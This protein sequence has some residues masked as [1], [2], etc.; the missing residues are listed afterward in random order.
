MGG[1]VALQPDGK[2]LVFSEPYTGIS[3]LRR[4]NPDGSAD[5]TF[6]CT[7]SSGGRLHNV[8]VLED[9]KILIAGLFTFVNGQSVK[10]LARLNANGS[11]DTSFAAQLDDGSSTPV[12]GFLAVEPDGSIIIEGEFTSAGGETNMDLARLDADGDAMPFVTRGDQGLQDID[13]ITRIFDGRFVA[14][15]YFL[16]ENEE[17]YSRLVR[18]ES[19]GEL[20]MSYDPDSALRSHLGLGPDRP[21]DSYVAYHI[22]TL[23][24]RLDGSIIAQGHVPDELNN[25]KERFIVLINSNG[26]ISPFDVGLVT[27]PDRD[28]VSFDDSEMVP[29]V[30]GSFLFSGEFQAEVFEGSG[31]YD[32]PVLTRVLQSVDFDG[33]FVKET[34]SLVGGITIQPNGKILSAGP[35]RRLGFQAADLLTV[36]GNTIHWTRN[37]TNQ[38]A[39]Y[40]H[41]E[42]WNGTS[43]EHL[44]A[45]TRVSTGWELVVENLPASGRVR[46]LARL[47]S[48]LGAFFHRGPWTSSSLVGAVTAYPASKITVKGNA[49]TIANHTDDFMVNDHRDFGMVT[50][51][52][53]PTITRTF[54]IH[55]TDTVSSQPLVI[56]DIDIEGLDYGDFAVSGITLPATVTANSSTTF[57]VTFTPQVTGGRRAAIVSIRSNDWTA[58]TYAFHIQGRDGR[59]EID[60][61]G[62]SYPVLD[63]STTPAL[64]N[65]TDFG[66]VNRVTG[67][68]SKSFT[69][70]NN[71]DFP[72]TIS[73]YQLTGTHHAQFSVTGLPT[74]SD[75]PVV[76]HSAE[77]LTFEVEL[78]ADGDGDRECTLTITNDDPDESPYNF[79][80]KGTG[81]LAAVEVS[82]TNDP[83]NG[84]Y[85][86]ISN[87]DTTPTT[88]DGT[89]FGSAAVGESFVTRNFKARCAGPFTWEKITSIVISGAHK[90]DFRVIAP[91]YGPRFPI[92]LSRDSSRLFQIKF[93]PRAPGIRSAK[94]TLHT[95]NASQPE[96]VFDI[97]GVGEHRMISVSGNGNEIADGDSTPNLADWTDFGNAAGG[98]TSVRT[99]TLASTGSQTLR[100]LGISVDGA[101]AAN[102]SLSS[103]PAYLDRSPGQTHSL[104]V[105]FTPEPTI[106][107]P[108]DYQAVITVTSDDSLT[109]RQTYTFNIKAR[110]VVAGKAAPEFTTSLSP[111]PATLSAI[112]VQPDGRVILGGSF[113]TSVT[114]RVRRIDPAGTADVSFEAALPSAA[115]SVVYCTAVQADGKIIIGGDFNFNHGTSPAVTYSGLIRVD[116]NGVLDTSFN[117]YIPTTTGSIR[118]IAIQTDNK[119][120]IGGNFTSVAGDGTRKHIARLLPS[121]AVDTTFTSTSGTT[122]LT[123]GASVN[124]IAL[125]TD[126]K[127]LVGGSF[128]TVTAVPTPSP[129]PARS[130]FVRLNADG[131]LDTGFTPTNPD[132]AVNCVLVQPDGKIL[133][134]GAFDNYTG[135]LRIARMTSGGVIEGPSSTPAFHGTISTGVVNSLALQADGKILVGGSFTTAGS[136]NTARNYLAR[137][138]DT[139]VFENDFNATISATTLVDAVTLLQDG[140][141]LIGGTFVTVSGA[142]HSKIALLDN[143]RA[144]PPTLQVTSSS[145]AE[146]LRGGS[147]PEVSQVTFERSTDDGDHWYPAGGAVTRISGGWEVTGA[148]LS[149]SG[150][151]RARGRTRGGSFNGSSGLVESVTSFG[152]SAVTREIQISGNDKLIMDGDTTPSTAD[153]TDFGTI[154]TGNVKVRHSFRLQNSGS[155]ALTID[156]ITTEG[157]NPADFTIPDLPSLPLAIPAYGSMTFTVVFEPTV[158]G[159]RAAVVSIASNDGDENPYTF[160]VK[161]SGIG[162]RMEILYGTTPV[163]NGGPASVASGTDFGTIAPANYSLQKTFTIKNTGNA[164]LTVSGR[165]QTGDYT[166][167][168]YSGLTLPTTITPGSNKTFVVTFDPNTDLDVRNAQYS[169]SSNDAESSPYVMALTGKGMAPF[170][171]KGK[172]NVITDGDTTPQAAD[173]TYLGQGTVGFPPASP[174]FEVKNISELPF[175][176]N[177]LSFGG[178]NATEFSASSSQ[179]LPHELAKGETLT[180][181]VHFIGNTASATVRSAI[182]NVNTNVTGITSLNSYNFTVSTKASGL[183]T[184]DE[185][186]NLGVPNGA[187]NTVVLQPDGKVLIGGTFTTTTSLPRNYIARFN[188]DSAGLLTLDDKFKPNLNGPVNT[189]VVED[190]GRILIG[191]SFTSVN[192]STAFKRIA[193][194][195]PDNDGDFIL[196]P[197]FNPIV[198]GVVNCIVPHPTATVVVGGIQMKKILVGG[199]FTSPRSRVALLHPV[200]GAAETSFPTADAEVKCIA[201]Q[202]DGKVLLGGNFT[203]LTP[204]VGSSVVRSRVARVSVVDGS[205]DPWTAS[206]TLNSS[207]NVIALESWG[208]ILLGGTFTFTSGGATYRRVAR[209]DSSTGALDTGFNPYIASGA[210][211]SGSVNTIALDS[212]GGITVGG[213]F[214]TVSTALTSRVNLTRLNYIDGSADPNFVSNTNTGAAVNCVTYAPNGQLWAGGTFTTIG[215]GTRDRVARLMNI[216]PKYILG[217]FSHLYGFQPNYGFIGWL[218]DFGAPL[219]V[220]IA[221]EYTPDLTPDMDSEWTPLGIPTFDGSHTW[222]LY[223]DLPMYGTVVATARIPGGQS[224]GS[225][226]VMEHYL[227][228]NRPWPQGAIDSSFRGW[229]LGS[230]KLY[231]ILAL[232][233]GG[234]IL[235]SGNGPRL[236]RALSDG[237]WDPTFNQAYSA[238]QLGTLKFII[239][240]PDGTLLVAYQDKL[241]LLE[242]DGSDDIEEVD[243]SGNTTITHA[244]LQPDGKVI[245]AYTTLA[246]GVYTTYVT[247][248]EE[249]LDADPTFTTA[250]L[251]G[252]VQAMTLQPNGNTL[253]GGAFTTVNGVT[254]NHIARLTATGM[255]DSAFDPN[256]GGSG[257]A[258]CFAVQ[259]NG[260]ILVGGNFDTVGGSSGKYDLVRLNVNGTLDTSFSTALSPS[261]ESFPGEVKSIALLTDGRIMIGGRLHGLPSNDYDSPGLVR[262]FANGALD[263]TFDARIPDANGIAVQKNGR[264]FR[265]GTQPSDSSCMRY[266]N[267]PDHA[268][269]SLTKVGFNRIQWLRGGTSPEV[270]NV[271]F[272][273]YNNATSTWSFRGNGTRV[274]GGWQHTEQTAMPTSGKIRAR[275][276]ISTGENNAS[277][278]FIETIINF[279]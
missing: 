224:N 115:S 12:I 164:D 271:T 34:A 172:G 247:R 97:K 190:D 221:F 83:L 80:L 275:G 204:A 278:G 279:P 1:L 209:F 226:G 239:V 60:V 99:F 234:K 228:F 200:D 249:D 244:V 11:L 19:N 179:T 243:I 101:N 161:G 82:G 225:S 277:S 274:N 92:W 144:T 114:Q 86:L 217:D 157:A 131:T 183:G 85:V 178:T 143:Q 51:T 123:L 220:D 109:A 49:L 193:R 117:P 251:N 2:M 269:E 62:D 155:E 140:R 187:V 154:A 192:D 22:E 66:L 53:S 41:F 88:S 81:A 253:I 229:N 35:E 133:L 16:D 248:L 267:Y 237:T 219:G 176:V 276:R 227:S 173:G 39:T 212:I 93:Q 147:A 170:E 9:G 213:T 148:S 63:G 185:L 90:D 119:I 210:T 222:E 162:S 150:L 270:E 241:V 57:Q 95:P 232:L 146:W 189:I 48:Q 58:S 158:P 6:T 32:W 259:P 175:T 258:I 184:Q 168:I 196:D 215:G 91:T 160:D 68:P 202:P 42:L 73:N 13:W 50:P 216:A 65:N 79:K 181:Q 194:L 127:V 96:Y 205:I 266:F 230:N 20:D 3:E 129:N 128:T 191:G 98:E 136:S 46:A 10:S 59:P 4:I 252:G 231:T 33:S 94:V 36:T 159:D 265:L 124:T 31:N 29:Q 44:G 89:D 18:I 272:D 74:S 201:V 177:S 110:G 45:G 236:G 134:A 111:T 112:A 7:I 145:R 166:Q 142:P 268:T 61:F 255:L 69:I 71:G 138:S 5:S 52:G 113:S 106:I 56:T 108:V 186:F 262:L 27:L 8:A 118:A 72:L 153:G 188:V 203:N 218:R 121:G 77:R 195:E 43:W 40:V 152:P 103:F 78:H 235:L 70:V 256:I 125:Q 182:F 104:V 17:E 254:R 141:V 126:G 64:L 246:S 257:A 122:S 54:S 250:V 264:V 38:E 75:E 174:T 28:V 149:G 163:V 137:F 156:S 240:R 76:L 238:S 171:G 30:D 100:L 47:E 21:D 199:T 233:P 245:M 37:G 116:Q 208:S 211:D 102:F 120:L 214:T 263:S 23:T 139:G 151:V 24:P 87:P 15:A 55:N 132:A 273:V 130:R 180:V 107:A 67:E 206:V 26:T 135:N 165:T 14:R 242:A 198:D 223:G 167:L 169:F 261:G 197:S 207:V 84:P 105:T 260:K 25:V